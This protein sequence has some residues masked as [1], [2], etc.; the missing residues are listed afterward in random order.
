MELTRRSLMQ[1]FGISVGVVS[2][3]E[4]KAITDSQIDNGRCRVINATTFCFSLG[5]AFAALNE[6][7]SRGHERDNLRW[8]FGIVGMTALEQ[9]CTITMIGDDAKEAIRRGIPDVLE[10]QFLGVRFVFDKDRPL[11]VAIEN[12]AT[13][14]PLSI[15]KNIAIPRHLDDMEFARRG[16]DA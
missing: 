1:G 14:K 10:H 15:I 5:I 12:A 4:A 7:L 8:R 11:L 6:V 13:G 16:E 3:G 2:A 9:L